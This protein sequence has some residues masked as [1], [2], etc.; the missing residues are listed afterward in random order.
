MKLIK[1]KHL[2]TKFDDG[3]TVWKCACC[4]YHSKGSTNGPPPSWFRIKYLMDTATLTWKE[5]Y[6]HSPRCL[7]VQYKRI[8]RMIQLRSGDLVSVDPENTG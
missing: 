7:A 3:K 8:K 6:V 5:E 2:P 4:G 1:Q